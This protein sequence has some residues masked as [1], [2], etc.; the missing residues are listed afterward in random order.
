MEEDDLH[1]PEWIWKD[2]DYDTNTGETLD[3]S[4]VKKG[5][6]EE[7]DRFHEMWGCTRM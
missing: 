4:L 2:A 5:K 1:E 6:Q 3:S 7:M